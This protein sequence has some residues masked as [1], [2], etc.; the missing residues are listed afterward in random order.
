[1]EKPFTE[2]EEAEFTELFYRIDP[3]GPAVKAWEEAAEKEERRKLE[4]QKKAAALDEFLANEHEWRE[5]S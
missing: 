5:S 4:L 3:M 1:M 2:A